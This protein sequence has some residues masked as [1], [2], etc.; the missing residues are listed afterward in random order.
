MVS[1]EARK[2]EINR[3]KMAQGTGMVRQRLSQREVVITDWKGECQG[4]DENTQAQV[5]RNRQERPLSES[6]PAKWRLGFAFKGQ[7]W[8][9]ACMVV[10]TKAGEWRGVLYCLLRGTVY[11]YVS[12]A[13]ILHLPAR[14]VGWCRGLRF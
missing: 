6:D 2:P 11:Q 1:R 9:T 13:L 12:P 7:G 4:S 3:K 8:D 14:S 10:E 5:V